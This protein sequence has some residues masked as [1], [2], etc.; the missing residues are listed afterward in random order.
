MA[1]LIIV[2]VPCA[3]G[4]PLLGEGRLERPLVCGLACIP[5]R[6]MVKPRSVWNTPLLDNVYD[7]IS[8]RSSEVLRSKDKIG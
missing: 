1:G 7:L 4:L 5:W 8:G 6:E 2:R 3:A